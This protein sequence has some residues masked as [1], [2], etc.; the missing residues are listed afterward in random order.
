MD[1]AGENLETAGA[2]GGGFDPAAS[3]GLFVGI[4]TF[5]DERIADVPFAVDDA[6]DLAHLF[7]IE[8]GLVAPECV[9]LLLAG[10]PKKE[11]SAERLVELLAQGARRAGARQSEIYRSL[12]VLASS[13]R[14]G[15]LA[16]LSIASH[17]VSDLGGDFLVAADSL[18]DRKLRTGVAVGELFEE[19]A[20]AGRGLVL[21]DA[22]REQVLRS[23]GAGEGI[24][25][26]MGKGFAE[27]IQSARG[28]VVLSGA[29]LGGF[30]YDDPKRRNGVFTAAVLDGLHG[31]A[32]AG[33]GGWITVRTLAD[34][35]QAQV[36]AWIRKEWPREE[37]RS[38]GIGR[39][40]EASAENLPLAPHPSATQERQRYRERRS[41]ALT[42][43]RELQGDVLSG[44]HWDQ[45]RRLLPAEEPTAEAAAL[46]EEIEALDDSVRSQRA[47]RDYL[48]E[49][50]GEVP[51]PVRPASPV[52]PPPPEVSRPAGRPVA[53]LPPTPIRAKPAVSRTTVLW[54]LGVI[55][56]TFALWGIWTVAA[57]LEEGRLLARES[58]LLPVSPEAGVGWDSPLGMRFHY[59][60][61]GTYTIGS[62]ETET[63]RGTDETLRK[64]TLTRGVWLGE[65]EVTQAQWLQLISNKKPWRFTGCGSSCPVENLSWYAVAEFANRLS[66]KEGLARCYQLTECEG[67][68]G[69]N[70][71]C[72]DPPAPSADC[73][74]YRL[75]TEAEWEVAARAGAES[76]GVNDLAAVA[77]FD[78]NSGSTPHPVGEKLA[79]AWG[80]H[81]LLG[82]VY[83]WTGDWYL[84]GPYRVFRGGSWYSPARDVR[85]AARLWYLP[86]ASNS[87]LGFR[88]ARGQDLHS[89]TGQ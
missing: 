79:N 7:A 50:A 55:A 51:L 83:E 48:R 52:V 39:R 5:E 36:V 72:K 9:A 34:Y 81:D 60:P 67:A 16:L 20:R 89:G 30:A 2:A 45:V 78:Q 10:E 4:S 17:G 14:P 12:G 21:L 74:G 71:T 44:G 75:P 58:A 28:L 54:A 77:W 87:T 26:A 53:S 46:L 33:P 63:G 18:T 23:R 59:V 31:G 76:F 49:G 22:C 70:Y 11:E 73:P 57:K 43:V 68:L 85:A 64:A 41:V 13:V 84:K 15:G 62:P 29:T 65:T 27:A 69:G 80:F 56:G 19:A 86:L 47:L 35:V 40:I 37:Q 25:G 38:R 82:N 8:L 66:D 88:L 1:R 3:A 24:G 42:R 32:A 6:V 61:S